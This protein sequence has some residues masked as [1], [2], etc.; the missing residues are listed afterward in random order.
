MNGKIGAGSVLKQKTTYLDERI[1]GGFE[2]DIKDVPWQVSL[3]KNG[4]HFCGGSIIS[5]KW[6]LTAAHCMYVFHFSPNQ[7]LLLELMLYYYYYHHSRNVNSDPE[8]LIIKSGTNFHQNGTES[9]VKRIIEDPKYCRRTRTYDF[10]LLELESELE[11]D[12]TRQV[13]KLAEWNDH[14]VDGSMCLVTGWGLTRNASEP[15]N[16]LR[17]VKV[18]IYPQAECNKAYEKIGAITS[19]MICAGY[20]EGG[21][22]SKLM[23][24]NFFYHESELFFLL[25]SIISMSRRFWWATYFDKEWSTNPSRSGVMGKRLC[26]S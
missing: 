4:S 13:I 25:L 11:L 2:I 23:C 18:P 17:G 16:I 24:F 9:K 20:K 21:K 14:H 22:D 5:P 15:E 6:I 12:E 8:H 7:N 19:S 10:A 1:V 26:A 3:Q